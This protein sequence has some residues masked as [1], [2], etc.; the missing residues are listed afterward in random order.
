VENPENA[1]KSLLASSLCS[2][3]TGPRGVSLYMLSKEVLTE[4]DLRRSISEAGFSFPPGWGPV[5]FAICFTFR[6][7]KYKN[8][9]VAKF[10]GF[11]PVAYEELP[12]LDVPAEHIC[13]RGVPVHVSRILVDSVLKEEFCEFHVACKRAIH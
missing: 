11:D 8:V 6:E 2:R 12:H 1:K 13:P 9:L 4:K 3:L 5:V 10:S 7:G